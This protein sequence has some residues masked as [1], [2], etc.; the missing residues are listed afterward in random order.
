MQ[1]AINF[2]PITT[3]VMP[4]LIVAFFSFLLAMLGTPIYTYFAFKHKAWKVARTN[5]VTGEAAPIYQK[6][7]AAKHRRNIPTMAGIV[8][9]IVVGLVIGALRWY[10]DPAIYRKELL[11]P[12]FGFVGAGCMGL[13][14][15]YLNIR[16]QDKRVAGLRAPLKLALTLMIA[17]IGALYFYYKLGYSLIHIPAVGDF[18]L[19]VF[20]IPLFML[21]IVSTANAVNIS[22]GL[23]GLSGGLTALA[24]SAFAIIAF[25]QGL[26]WLAA[27]CASVVGVV[28]AYTW[29]NIHPARFFMGDSGSFALGT[30]LGMVAMLTN[31]VFVLPIIGLV[32]VIEAGSSVI[33][34]VSKRIFK[35]KVFLSA[36][37]HHHL[38]AIGW[39]ETKITMRF[40]VIGAVS[41]TLG[42]IIG[43]IAKG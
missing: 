4:V 7:H 36:P 15:D 2:D 31:S 34:I 40:W 25:F 29:F 33:Q 23:D 28:L 18:E 20:Y 21:V 27:F 10:L 11:L 12:L 38:E 16:G 5:A 24:Y 8:M 43:L 39:P 9:I 3:A 6:L 37:I 42:L 26:T 41:A 22:D 17:L 30:G 13:L 19:G 14:D 32:F 35:R 1:S